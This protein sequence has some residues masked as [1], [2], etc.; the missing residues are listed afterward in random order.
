MAPKPPKKGPNGEVNQ[1]AQMEFDAAMHETRENRKAVKKL[2]K[3]GLWVAIGVVVVAIGVGLLHAC[4]VGFAPSSKAPLGEDG[5]DTASQEN[6]GPVLMTNA[7]AVTN[8]AT[9]AVA[10]AASA[11]KP[12]PT[13]ANP[14]VVQL[15]GA[16]LQTVP[17]QGQVRV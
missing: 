16:D 3:G 8:A 11:T 15:D 12:T 10:P 1:V 13:T 14:A 9:A 4:G 17:Q 7:P 6:N 5:S 2:T